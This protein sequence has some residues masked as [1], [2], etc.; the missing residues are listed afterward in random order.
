GARD[1]SFPRDVRDGGSPLG[2]V[3]HVSS[4]LRAPVWRILRTPCFRHTECAPHAHRTGS[5]FRIGCPEP[6]RGHDVSGAGLR[7]SPMRTFTFTDAPH[8]RRRF[9]HHAPAPPDRLRAARHLARKPP[10][11]VVMVPAHLA[12]RFSALYGTTPTGV[13]SA[14]GR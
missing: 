13:W 11:S 12:D 1:T 9:A 7:Y 10:R 14:P 4:S 3:S 2:T 8:L 6:R 5:G